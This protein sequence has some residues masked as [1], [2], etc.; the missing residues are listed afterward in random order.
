[1][2]IALADLAKLPGSDRLACLA[3]AIASG[4]AAL[5]VLTAK[6]Y[7]QLHDDTLENLEIDR[8]NYE[9]SGGAEQKPFDAIEPAK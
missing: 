3:R 8:R 9:A 1:M 6:A 7:P 5:I 2:A 4:K